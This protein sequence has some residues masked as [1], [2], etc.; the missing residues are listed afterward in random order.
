[1][2]S[3]KPDKND[4]DRARREETRAFNELEYRSQQAKEQRQ[5]LDALLK[6][7]KECLDGLANARDT[8]LTPVHVREYQLLM[9][10]I[11]SAVELTEI[12]VSAC[13]SNLEEAREQWE[14]KNIEYEKIRDAVIRNASP[15]DVPEITEPEEPFVEQYYKRDRR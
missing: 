5:Q 2:S 14:K 13:E 1:M 4:L 11:N 3:D 12:K 6:Y 8:G 9:A 10:H 15:G 7:R